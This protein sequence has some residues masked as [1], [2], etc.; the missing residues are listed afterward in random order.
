MK[1]DFLNDGYRSINA[2]LDSVRIVN[3]NYKTRRV[4]LQ[5]N[6]EKKREE[7]EKEIHRGA[8]STAKTATMQTVQIHC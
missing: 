4:N 5:V 1:R 8:T 3:E 6:G 7:T 2:H